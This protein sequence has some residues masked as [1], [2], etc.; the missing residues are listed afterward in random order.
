MIMNQL[1]T[2]PTSAIYMHRS[3]VTRPQCGNQ[4]ESTHGLSGS[5]VRRQHFAEEIIRLKTWAYSAKHKHN[6]GFPCKANL[7]NVTHYYYNYPLARPKFAG[8]TTY[9]LLNGQDVLACFFSLIGR[10]AS[11]LW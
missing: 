11:V 10:Y 1:V 4:C 6:R 7:G 2:V 9:T 5:L 3:E 8:C